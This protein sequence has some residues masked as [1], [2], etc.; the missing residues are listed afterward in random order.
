MSFWQDH[1]TPSRPDEP[2][3]HNI[4][5]LLQ[6]LGRLSVLVGDSQLRWL[7]PEKGVMHV[8]IGAVVNAVWDL[9]AKRAGVPLWKLLADADPAWLA[10]QVDCRYIVD[11]LTPQEALALLR[12]GQQNKA[13]REALLR[14]RGYLAYT[15][16]PG[17]LGYSD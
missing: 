7:G 6:T 8:A 17:W 2:D 9:A 10:S 3:E 1:S 14:A 11:A 16:S 12:R 4:S 15:T 5:S 13:D